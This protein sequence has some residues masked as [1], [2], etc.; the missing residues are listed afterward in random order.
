[1][2]FTRLERVLLLTSLI[3]LP[4]CI[5]KANKVLTLSQ[6]KYRAAQS[7]QACIQ[8]TW[9]NGFMVDTIF[10]QYTLTYDRTKTD[11]NRF[12]KYHCQINEA[13]HGYIGSRIFDGNRTQ[14][15]HWKDNTINT[16]ENPG[17]FEKR[18]VRRSFPSYE[19]PFLSPGKFFWKWR[20]INPRLVSSDSSHWIIEREGISLVIRKSDSLIEYVRYDFIQPGGEPYF[21]EYHFV[22]QDFNLPDYQLSEIYQ[23]EDSTDNP[24]SVTKAIA[25]TTQPFVLAPSFDLPTQY[26]DSLA[27]E[28]LKGK[29]VLLDFWSDGCAPCI[30]AMPAHQR[31]REEYS[32]KGVEVVGVYISGDDPAKLKAFLEGRGISYPHVLAKSVEP[33]LSKAYGRTFVPMLYLIDQNGYIVHTVEGA[34]RLRFAGLK[35]KLN[36]LLE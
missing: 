6:K 11:E 25:D 4:S 17:Y 34:S 1:M 19:W 13:T 16:K 28:D 3:I 33:A 8:L 36:Q 22:Y 21:E 20:Y 27:L 35:R 29:V 31:L 32:D 7:G 26:G 10:N 30:E 5:F 14:F 2:R 9:Q 23:V 15:I 12:T 24:Y 18:S